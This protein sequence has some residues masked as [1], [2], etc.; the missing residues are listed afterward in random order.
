VAIQTRQ[1]ASIN[2]DQC[3]IR[4][5]YDDAGAQANVATRVIWANLLSSPV[6]CW[7]IKPDGTVILDTTLEPNSPEQSRNL[8]GN[9][10]WNVETDEGPSVNLAS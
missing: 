5:Q 1:M 2:N 4:V 10:R 3:Y 9:Q 7:V 6:R 8:P